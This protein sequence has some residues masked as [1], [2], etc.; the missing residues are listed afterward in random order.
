MDGAANIEGSGAGVVLVGP[1]GFKSEHALKFKFQTT[2]NVAEYEALIY[3]LKLASELKVQNIKIFSDS[4]LVVGQVNAQSFVYRFGI[5]KRIIT[6]NGPQFRAAALRS[7]CDDYGIELALT[8]VYAPQSNGQ[9]KSTNKIVL[10]GLKTRVLAAQSN[11]VDE[12]NKVLWSCR[13][14]PS[15]ATSETPFSLAY[16]VEAIIPVEVGCHLIEQVGT[17]IITMSNF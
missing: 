8:S 3:G 2:D 14:T 17:T 7:F 12:L 15:S 13:I 6:D 11:W 4:Q 10:R 16:G 9:V 5:P 1:D